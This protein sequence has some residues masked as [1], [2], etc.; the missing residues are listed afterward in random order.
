MGGYECPLQLSHCRMLKCAV[1]CVAW[2]PA[3]PHFSISG[4]VHNFSAPINLASATFPLSLPTTL[5]SHS[6]FVPVFETTTLI[7]CCVSICAS[8]PRLPPVRA[9]SADC[10]FRFR[11][12]AR[13]L[14]I[15]R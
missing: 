1:A 11:L 14:R 8:S 7:R 13:H 5:P 15:P 6:Y 3:P 2:Q 12:L 10:R 4:L 9:E